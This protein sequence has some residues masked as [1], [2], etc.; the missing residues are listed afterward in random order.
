MAVSD[1][2]Y[3]KADRYVSAGQ[4]QGMFDKEFQLDVDGLG[5][6]R[7]PDVVPALRHGQMTAPLSVSRKTS[8]RCPGLGT[9]DHRW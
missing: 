1:A 7:V 4:L 6:D 5:D 2:V 9:T 8:S 3:G